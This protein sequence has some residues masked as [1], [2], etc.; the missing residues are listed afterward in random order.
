M[1]EQIWVSSS[2][3]RAL[4]R[5]HDG[6][7]GAAGLDCYLRIYQA[8]KYCGWT[9][10]GGAVGLGLTSSTGTVT[11][12]PVMAANSVVGQRRAAHAKRRRHANS[13]GTTE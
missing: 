2:P 12:P 3:G 6:F 8:V 10:H 9:M 11:G 1:Q 4:E 5:G 13:P 7:R